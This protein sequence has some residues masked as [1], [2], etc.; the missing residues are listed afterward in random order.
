M[1]GG[2]CSGYIPGYPE[3]WQPSN[4]VRFLRHEKTQSS[5]QLPPTFRLTTHFAAR[6]PCFRCMENA[7]LLAR[8]V[9]HTPQNGHTVLK[10]PSTLGFQS[11]PLST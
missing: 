2:F 5:S 6:G 4:R 7:Q 10:E 3:V 9:S 8:A 1:A 11:L